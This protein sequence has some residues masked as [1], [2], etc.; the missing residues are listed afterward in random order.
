M[1]L[2]TA[3]MFRRRQI[4]SS[5]QTDEIILHAIAFSMVA[6]TDFKMFRFGEFTFHQQLLISFLLGLLSFRGSEYAG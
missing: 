2:N 3:T 6:I 4:S 5:K 1:P